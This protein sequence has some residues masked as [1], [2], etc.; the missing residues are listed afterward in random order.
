[1]F[2]KTV[3]LRVGY[4]ALFLLTTSAGWSATQYFQKAQ[5]YNLGMT[6]LSVTAADVNGDGKLDL[7]VADGGSTLGVSLG[8]GDGTFPPA[9]TYNS[10]GWRT[11]A[12]VVGDLNAD[13]HLDLVA[14]S[15]CVSNTDCT[16]GVVA[17]LPGNGDGTFRAAQSYDSGGA[18]ARA[19]ALADVNGDRNLDL[20]VADNCVSNGNCTSG[21]ATVLLGNGDGTFQAARSYNSGG[22]DSSGVA[23]AD[24]DGDGKLDLLV[25]NYTG[26]VGVLLGNGDGTFQAAQSYATDNGN[27][28]A[29]GDA[30]QDGRPDVFLPTYCGRSENC[31]RRGVQMLLGSGGGK[32]QSVRTF[33][34]GGKSGT[35]IAVQDVS[36]DGKLDM[37]VANYCDNGNTRCRF[38][39]VGLLLG[40]GDGT[41]QKAQKYNSG[42]S[43]ALAVAIG[44]V[45]GDGKADLLVANGVV[46]VL[47]GRAR[48]VPTTNF[49]S[50]LNPS[51]YGQSVILTAT[52]SSIGPNSPT[53]TVAFRNG[54]QTVGKVTLNA[55][56]ATLIT[57]KLPAGTLSLTATYSGDSDTARGTSPAVIQVVTPATS[58]TT[59]QS[60]LNP[61]RLGQPVRFSATVTSPTAKITGTVTF[62]AGTTTLGTVMLSGG[63]ARIT[64]SALPK[65]KTTVTATYDGTA[66]IAAS[67]AALAQHVH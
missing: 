14:T 67:S 57:T 59:I 42:S 50:G 9:Q 62:T 8:K 6:A 43:H 53:G 5:T 2:S 36:R 60:S 15:S 66:N 7:L 4:L 61:S 45:N 25:S 40:N 33:Y 29:V 24:V 56:V 31:M 18:D 11:Y 16:H 3:V 13:G 10:G 28:I 35:A 27:A 26:S 1:M 46:S 64:T 48:Y 49:S 63:T 38:G 41:F 34:S 12:I 39:V 58:L 54:V 17:V 22:Q 65:G 19:V 37:I 51:V 55:G 20:I 21:A 47:L 30:N 44:D 32:F 23:V 52:V